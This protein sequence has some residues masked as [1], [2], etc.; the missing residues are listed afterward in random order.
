M[1]TPWAAPKAAD[2]SIDHKTLLT[3]DDLIDFVD[4]LRFSSNEEKH[5]PSHLYEAKIARM[6]N[7][8]RN[9]GEYY[10]PPTR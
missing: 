7:A 6:G 3:G 2:G 10:T 1:T 5:E 9:G 4:Q 8:G